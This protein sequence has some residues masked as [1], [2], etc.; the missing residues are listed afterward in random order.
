MI[1]YLSKFK[2]FSKI[3]IFD[4]QQNASLTSRN[5]LKGPNVSNFM[6]GHRVTSIQNITAVTGEFPAQKPVTRNMFPCDEV[7]MKTGN[8]DVGDECP[9]MKCE[10]SAPP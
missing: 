3:E 8:R 7:I 4:S 5:I 10:V 6:E 1:I 2:S 9:S